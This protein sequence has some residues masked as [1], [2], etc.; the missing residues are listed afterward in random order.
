MKSSNTPGGRRL[1]ALREFHK[2]TQLDVELDASL[3]IGYLQRLEL[4]R[5]KQPERDTLE[6]ILSAL[7]ARYTERREIL[8]LFGYVVDAP[9]P[10]E[11]EVNWAISV[12]QA[13]LESAVFPA[14]IL[15]CSHRL[16]FW[17]AL[18]P[19]LFCSDSF[20]AERLDQL[21][22]LK[23]VFDPQYHLTPRIKNP[24]A[25]FPAQIRA[26]RYEMQHFHEESWYVTLIEDMLRCDE[27][28]HYW[29]MEKGGNVQIAARPLTPLV[30]EVR[31]HL[32]SFRIISEPYV[33]DNRFRVIY[34]LP[35]DSQTTQQC[36]NW[37]DKTASV[38]S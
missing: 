28:K 8:E 35:A 15:D 33:Q 12:S 21:S 30:L 14:Y 32:L 22:M 27:F 11:E 7:H 10:T 16:L 36:L 13:D 6:R 2:Q 3:G 4:G 18:T 20:G 24:D 19:K 5:V 23:L 38:S 34:Y 26:L 25:F 1:R 17:N 9:I 31:G 37:L 29:H